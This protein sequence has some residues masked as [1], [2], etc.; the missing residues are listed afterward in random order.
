[1]FI[2]DHFNRSLDLIECSE[3]RKKLA[4]Y[5]LMAGHRQRLPLHIHL[6]CSISGQENHYCPIIRGQLIISSSYDIY[7]EL[8]QAEYLSANITTAEELFD[9]VIEKSKNELE[10]AAVYGL[11]VTLYAGVGKYKEAVHTGIHSLRRLGVRIPTDPTKFDYLMELLKYK[12]QMFNR[13]I[14]S[15]EKSARN[16]ET[17]AGKSCGLLSRMAS[18]TMSSHP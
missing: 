18:V 8:A 2:M 10:R 17:G 4:E 3:E 7:L 1:M 13:N 5:N 12:W 16:E 14:E 6:R 11:K 9:T 15:L